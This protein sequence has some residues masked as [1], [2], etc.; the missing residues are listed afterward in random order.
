MKALHPFNFDVEAISN[1]VN[2][3]RM[4]MSLQDYAFAGESHTI[5]GPAVAA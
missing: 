3:E 5:P 4:E 2:R 1:A